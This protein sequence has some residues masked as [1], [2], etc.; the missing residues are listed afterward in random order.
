[1]AAPE[2]IE[3]INP[4][5][6]EVLKRFVPDTE[7]KVEQALGHAFTAFLD[8]RKRS[9][10]GAGRID[11]PGGRTPQS[12]RSRISPVIITAEM[13]KPLVEAEAE[14]EKCAWGC[15]YYADNAEKVSPG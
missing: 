8:W 12:S 5:T 10:L 1:M 14:I 15:E 2:P 4:A 7:Q 11:A 3:S 6:E 13:G 9:V